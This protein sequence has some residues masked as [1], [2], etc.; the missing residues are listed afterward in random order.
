MPY[1][2][3]SSQEPFDPFRHEKSPDKKQ[4]VRKSALESD[5]LADAEANLR[6]E[7]IKEK[8]WYRRLFTRKVK[9][10]DVSHEY[11]LN[12]HVKYLVY[13]HRGTPIK[14]EKDG[15]SEIIGYGPALK[16]T[17]N[18]VPILIFEDVKGGENDVNYVDGERISRAD[19]KFLWKKLYP[20][21]NQ[22]IEDVK[23][24]QKKSNLRKEK[25]TPARQAI[26][27]LLGPRGK[28]LDTSE[29]PKQLTAKSETPAEDKDAPDK[30]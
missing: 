3:P 26:E 19:A 16:G 11:A 27:R 13:Y 18:N 14:K 29:V 28:A 25:A 21:S 7:E 23:E 2:E 17:F 5:R 8:P 10:V 6:N 30:E 4:Y 1:R 15:R 9:G 22:A 12:E 20:M 24:S